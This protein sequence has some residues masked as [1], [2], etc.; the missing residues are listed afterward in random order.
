[1]RV[2]GSCL[3]RSYDW[4]AAY[5]QG[6]FIDGEVVYCKMPPGADLDAHGKPMLG[7]DG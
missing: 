1:M 6:D 3:V 2:S 7:S 4:V 5:L